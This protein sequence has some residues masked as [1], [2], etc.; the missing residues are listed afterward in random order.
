MPMDTMM[1]DH[2]RRGSGP[3]CW[4]WLSRVMIEYSRAPRRWPGPTTTIEAE[5]AVVHDH[6]DQHDDDPADAGEQ[7]G[8]EGVLADGGGHRLHGLRGEAHRAGSRT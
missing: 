6:V 7:P 8:L 2:A 5:Q 4:S 3:G 1:P